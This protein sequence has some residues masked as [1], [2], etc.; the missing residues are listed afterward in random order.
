M[1]KK[2]SPYGMRGVIWYQGESDAPK[3]AVYRS[4][5]G[6]LI[7]CWRELWQ[8]QFP[9]L[10]VQLAPFEGYRFMGGSQYPI[11]RECQQ[12]VADQVENVGMAVITDCGMRYDIHPKNK[13]LVGERLALQAEKRVYN[14][15]VVCEGPRLLKGEWEKGS[16]VLTFSDSGTRLILRGQEIRGLEIFQEQQSILPEI[17][18]V[19]GNQVILSGDQLDSRK[20]AEIRLA[21]SAYYQIN[22]YSDVGLPA[23]PGHLM[24]EAEKSKI[25]QQPI[26]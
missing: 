20:Q 6:Q 19:Q 1:L 4:V 21:C 12:Q 25:P 8:E 16:L 15:P 11:I 7:K 22:L 18:R 24:I 23:R 5:F 3:E 17:T 13:K 9:F 26:V 2:V 14:I 10:F